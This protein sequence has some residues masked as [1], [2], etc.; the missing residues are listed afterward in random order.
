MRVPLL[1]SRER[2]IL[3][4]TFLFSVLAKA[5]VLTPFANFH[6]F[7]AALPLLLYFMAQ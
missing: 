6:L 2:N 1:R 4:N 7:R 5:G 3:P